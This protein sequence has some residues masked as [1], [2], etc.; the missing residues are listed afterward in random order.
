LSVVHGRPPNYERIAAIMGEPRS[1]WCITYAPHVY[2]LGDS[3]GLTPDLVVHEGTHL[4]QQGDDPETWW[5]NWLSDRDFRRDQEL[6]A[7]R[8]QMVKLR[9]MFRDRND[10]TRIRVQIASDLAGPGYGRLMT[11]TEA[12]RVLA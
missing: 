10:L 3:P 4:R 11:F 1:G 8:A 5:T 6:E 9:Q 2:I 12:L 7:Y